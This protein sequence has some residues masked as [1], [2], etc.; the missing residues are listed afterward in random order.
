M[1]TV[2]LYVIF[3]RKLLDANNMSSI[4]N[5]PAPTN[6]VAAVVEI[7]V[8]ATIAKLASKIH[9]KGDVGLRVME[10]VSA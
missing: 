9:T 7:T 8:G 1:L 10:L 5:H 6:R 2:L 4:S 3:F